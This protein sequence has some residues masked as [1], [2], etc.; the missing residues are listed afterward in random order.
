MWGSQCGQSGSLKVTSLSSS[1]KATSLSSSVMVKATSLSSSVKG[2]SLVALKEQWREIAKHMK[3]KVWS[4][5]IY[6]LSK[7]VQ[8]YM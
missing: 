1:V 6:L 2:T 7:I 5:W 3:L 4:P 8:I